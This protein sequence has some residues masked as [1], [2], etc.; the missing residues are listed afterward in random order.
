MSATRPS[1]IDRVLPHSALEGKDK[2]PQK[3]KGFC[4]LKLF[5]TDCHTFMARFR[6]ISIGTGKAVPPGEIEA[7][8]AVGFPR[9]DRV[10]NAVHVRSY[11]EKAQDSI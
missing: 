5:E 6:L 10:V 3:R 7:E 1:L 11:N 4:F 2:H 8:I 9:N